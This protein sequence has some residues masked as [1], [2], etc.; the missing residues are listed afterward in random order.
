MNSLTINDLESS[1]DLDAASMT[2]INGGMFPM[3]GGFGG[4]NGIGQG[5]QGISAET[6][7]GD[8]FASPTTSTVVGVNPQLALILDLN[9]LVDLGDFSNFGNSR[10]RR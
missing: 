8:G 1:K 6:I 10:H 2:N 5:G 3:K 9:H 7:G 4:F